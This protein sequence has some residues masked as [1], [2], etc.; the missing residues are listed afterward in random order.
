MGKT[1]AGREDG[2]KVIEREIQ[3]Q[4]RLGV[5]DD[6]AGFETGADGRL[7]E[8]RDE[9][10]RALALAMGARDPEDELL[11]PTPVRKTLP[12]AP[13]RDRLSWGLGLV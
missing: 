13:D 10:C 9:S 4:L 11:L 5:L 2:S 12:E 7:T 8:G 6:A 1:K 3:N